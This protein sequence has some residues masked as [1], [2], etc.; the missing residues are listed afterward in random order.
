MFCDSNKNFHPKKNFYFFEPK[1]S[2]AKLG[3]YLLFSASVD[4]P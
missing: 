1:H 3:D 2:L 4:A